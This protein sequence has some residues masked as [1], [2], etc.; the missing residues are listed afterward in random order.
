MVYRTPIEKACWMR[1]VRGQPGF[2]E[3]WTVNSVDNLKLYLR[4]GANGMI[5]DPQGIER[6][7]TLLQQPEFSQRYRLAQRFDDPMAPDNFAYGLT[8]KTTEKGSAG[9]D[10][11]ITFTLT[12]E[13]GSA[14]VKVDTNFNARMESGMTNFVVLHSPDLGDLESIA[15]KSD[16]S[17]N[18]P[19]WHL[20]SIVVE[21]H[22]Y[23]VKKVASFKT[24]IE[25]TGSVTRNLV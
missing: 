8:V 2:V 25:T 18:A 5:C 3:A 14:S 21:S 10:A 17:H 12:G 15:V 1:A 20:D 9:T 4:L 7:R 6:V 19:G 24:W 13:K 11:T 23:G 22:R 16:L